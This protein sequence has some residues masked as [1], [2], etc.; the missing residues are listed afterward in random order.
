MKHSTAEPIDIALRY[1]PRGVEATLYD[2][3]FAKHM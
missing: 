1:Y 3:L 2:C